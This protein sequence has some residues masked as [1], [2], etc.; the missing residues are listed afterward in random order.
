[1]PAKTDNT[2]GKKIRIRLS[3]KGLRSF[4]SGLI[5][6]GLD[7][8]HIYAAVFSGVF[9][10]VIPIYGFQTLA[11]IGVAALFGLN[12]PLTFGATFINNPI[13][14]P[15]LIFCS[16][17]LGHLIRHGE[18]LPIASF[19][20]QEL[21]LKSQLADWIA[22]SLIL[23]LVLG[24]I[25]AFCVTIVY[26]RT[27]NHGG[28]QPGL[29]AAEK[30]IRRLFDTSPRFAR[31]F[32]R[33]KLRL[34]KIFGF[35]FVEDLHG[36]PAV[37][38][39]CGYGIALAM[40]A[41]RHPGLPLIGCD[42]DRDRVRVANQAL[43]SLNAQLSV[44]DMRSFRFPDAGLIMMIDVLQYLNREEQVGL[45]ERC[46]S[47]LQPHGK[48][49]FRV[50]AKD[51]GLLSR[52][53]MAFDKI[54][55]RS[56]GNRMQPTVLLSEEYEKI[57]QDANMLIHKRRMTNRLPLAHI[58]FTAKKPGETTGIIDNDET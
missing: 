30:F 47:A 11:A 52:L 29:R 24:A 28:Q 12:K 10:G 33:W 46:C 43:S 14:Q 55:F 16:I 26:S 22:G 54:I 19:R 25:A 41:F 40:A 57:L 4:L 56:T 44:H 58:L 27:H 38:L 3:R 7:P 9:I 49:I 13:L 42:L 5:T 48:L 1:M 18:F 37:D 34:D 51:S 50:P 6:E 45:L 15:F 53:T 21:D 31:G 8:R 39:G 23:G 20:I 17:E 2:D 35:L 36:G 32:V